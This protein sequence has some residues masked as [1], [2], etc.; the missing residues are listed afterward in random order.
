VLI[1]PDSHVSWRGDTIKDLEVAK[2]IIATI[3][4]SKMSVSSPKVAFRTSGSDL[5]VTRKDEV[6]IE[7]M[8]DFQI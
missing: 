1:R 8:G 2:Q 7:K 3:V 5:L 4:G 6:A